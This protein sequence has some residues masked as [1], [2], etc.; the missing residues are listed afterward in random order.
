MVVWTELDLGLK[1]KGL[2]QNSVGFVGKSMGKHRVAK[3]IAWRGNTSTVHAIIWSLMQSTNDS[4][5][6]IQLSP[7]EPC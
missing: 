6:M 4:G 7:A 2:S 5:N 1:P 3:T